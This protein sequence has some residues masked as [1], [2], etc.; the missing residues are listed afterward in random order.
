MFQELKVLYCW[1]LKGKPAEIYSEL[2]FHR[3]GVLRK[4]ERKVEVLGFSVA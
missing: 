1:Q 2:S 4:T 3:T